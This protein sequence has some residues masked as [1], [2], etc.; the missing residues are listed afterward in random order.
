MST[1]SATLTCQTC[2]VAA[3]EEVPLDWVSSIE[4]GELQHHCGRCVRD[5]LRSIEAR[6]DPAWW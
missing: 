2:G 5:N 4:R 3:G 6:L 1:I